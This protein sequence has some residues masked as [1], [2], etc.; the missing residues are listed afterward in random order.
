MPTDTSSSASK[1]LL[2]APQFFKIKFDS[3]LRATSENHLINML[4]SFKKSLNAFVVSTFVAIFA[5]IFSVSCAQSEAKNVTEETS[6]KVSAKATPV[7]VNI[8]ANDNSAQT[9]DIS[10]PKGTVVAFYTA[11][12][13]KR[14]QQAFLMTNWKPAVEGL[15]KEEI[16]DL[17]P[18]F[19]NLAALLETQKL[20]VS[21]E[22]ISGNL[23]S[24][25]V[26]AEE[27]E[28]GA[29]KNDE[30]KLRKEN[31][32][33]MMILGD[34][35]AEAVVKKAGKSYFFELRI[36]THQ[37]E[38]EEMLQRITKAEF[39][40]G[41]QNGGL[42]ADMNK[43]I[44]GNFVPADIKDENTFGYIFRLNLSADKRNYSVNAEPTKYGKTGRLSYLLTIGKDG[45]SIIKKEDNKGQPIN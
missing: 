9:S 33:W 21:G 22:Q 37:Q 24:V 27:M 40:N 32:G 3:S 17:Q 14:F 29:P 28:T 45:K 10:T 44:E 20:E 34:E 43:L 41:V 26:K 38:V 19:A 4:K 5:V 8:L 12:R 36:E 15:T 1:Y 13:E 23:A 11:I 6:S 31:S 35:Q 30:I 39:Y 18:D 7:A 16:E 42:Y 25:F 2:F